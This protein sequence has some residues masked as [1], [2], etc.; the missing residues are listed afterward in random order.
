VTSAAF[1]SDDAQLVTR[2]EDR[3]LRLWDARTGEPLTVLSLDAG[4]AER[5]TAFS[6][7]GTRLACASD[8]H[9]VLLWD[10]GLLE[11]TGVLRGHR[12]FVYDVAFSPDGTQ[13][14]SAA[15]DGT[16]RLW[17]ATSQRQISLFKHEELIVHAVA[18]SSDGKQLVSVARGLEYPRPGT[19]YV[20]ELATGRLRYRRQTSRNVPGNTRV[21]VN[22]NASLV[23]VATHGASAEVIELSSGQVSRVL[24]EP[25]ASSADV[26]FSTDGRELAT[27]EG[28][29]T[30]RL[31]N[32]ATGSPVAVLRGHQAEVSCVRYSP[33]GQRIASASQDHTVR[34]W[35]AKTQTEVA[36]FPHGSNV[37]GLAFSPDSS[38]LATA[39]QDNTIRLWDLATYDEV[40]ELHGHTYYVHAVAFSPDGTRLA[41]GSGD[42]TVRI[43]DTLSAHE[44]A[45]RTRPESGLL[46]EGTARSQK[47][48]RLSGVLDVTGPSP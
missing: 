15:W 29:G 36:L 18:F 34:L 27:G 43:W 6:P 33:D 16:V 42:H 9:Q 25:Q 10:V 30:V 2:G 32:V 8:N 35:D 13:V 48:D 19:V 1:R 20:W 39:C 44:R 12:S 26:A 4:I 38:R 17:D 37:Y 3:S 31:W 11:R 14:A 7:D 46:G 22:R 24:G 5:G 21:A 23:A 40:V 28:D 45:R 41:S 47:S